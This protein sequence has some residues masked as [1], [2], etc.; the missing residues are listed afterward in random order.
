MIDLKLAVA[1]ELILTHFERWRVAMKLNVS[2]RTMA[3][4][5]ELLVANYELN[6]ISRPAFYALFNPENA[7]RM[8]PKKVVLLQKLE[9]MFRDFGYFFD[10]VSKSYLERDTLEAE[11]PFSGVKNRIDF[12]S[13]PKDS[14]VI[15]QTFL[16]S[17]PPYLQ[18]LQQSYNSGKKIEIFFP[19]PDADFPKF[20]NQPPHPHHGIM[21]PNRIRENTSM[22]IDHWKSHGSPDNLKLYHYPS[23]MPFCIYGKDQVQMIAHFYPHKFAV[24]GK[25]I[26]VDSHNAL[27]EEIIEI[28]DFLRKESDRLI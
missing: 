17:C 4:T 26:K 9:A 6:N 5:Y 27:A 12:L 7:N 23:M 25:F 14:I 15:V 20:R 16:V 21:I 10:L 24:H 19:S 3:G 1:K 2:S 28:L 11:I 13:N 18:L 22:I 8:I